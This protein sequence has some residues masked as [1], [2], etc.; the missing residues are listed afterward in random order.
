MWEGLLLVFFGWLLGLLAPVI[1]TYINDK[2]KFK[3]I[4]SGIS[5][6]LV[7]LQYRLV[8]AAYIFNLDYGKFDHEFLH[9]MKKF[10]SS[11]NGINEKEQ[12][13][14]SVD[15]LLQV[16]EKDLQQTVII[17]RN[18]LVGKSVKH[19]RIPFLESQLSNIG[20]FSSDKQAI[21]LEILE[22]AKI[23][24]ETVGDAKKYHSMTFDQDIRDV[25]REI[26]ES[27]LHETYIQLAQRCRIIA[28]RIDTFLK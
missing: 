17:Q 19:V 5:N 27:S 9:W 18:K 1:A 11:Y 25:N 15:S 23:H 4:K 26:V 14:K 13:E 20:L 3:T 24:N 28:E 6:E 7:E 12:I 22:H 2:K 8:S 21:L 16:P 10:C